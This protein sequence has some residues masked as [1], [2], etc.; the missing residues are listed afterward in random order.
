MSQTKIDGD[1]WYV[2]WHELK[3]NSGMSWTSLAC[4]QTYED[5]LHVFGES[6]FNTLLEI[7]S[8]KFG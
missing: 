2:Q 6:G 5:Y 7:T 1:V 4:G 8:T 3:W